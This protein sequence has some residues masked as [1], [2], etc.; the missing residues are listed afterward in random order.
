M[1]GIRPVVRPL[2]PRPS[3][4]FER[5]EAKALLR[6][7]RAGDA[8]ALARARA[9]HDALRSAA[10]AALKLADAQLVIAREYGFASWPRLVRYFEQA[11]RL[12]KRTPS[13]VNPGLWGLEALQAAVPQFIAQHERRST[14][15]ARNL[16]AY[17]PR[18][19]GMP[20]EQ[21]FDTP[22]TEDDARLVIARRNGF[23]TWDALVARVTAEANDPMRRSGLDIPPLRRAL[24]AISAANLPGLQAVTHAHP[25][26]LAPGEYEVATTMQLMA[27]ALRQ[28]RLNVQ[29]DA[30]PERLQ[31]IIDWLVT[32][33]FDLQRELDIQLCGDMRM[34]PDDVQYWIDRGANPNW[35]AP[36]GYSV[37]EHAIVRYRNPAAIDRLAQYA[38]VREPAFWMCAGLG[39]IAGAARYFDGDGRLSAAARAHRPQFDAIAPRAIPPA[40]GDEDDDI[41]HEAAFVAFLCDRTGMMELLISRGL[42]VD[43]LRWETPLVVMAVGNGTVEMTETLIRC[44]ADL[45]LQGAGNGSAREMAREMLESQPPVDVRRRRAARFG[46]RPEPFDTHRRIAELCGLDPD[47]IL[48]ARDARPVPPPSIHPQLTSV[49]R[50]ASDDARRAGALAV[51][52]EHLMYG[53]LRAGYPATGAF[54]Q[55]S[56]MDTDRFRADVGHRVL[57]TDDLLDGETLPLD[58][59][60][61]AVMQAA[62]RIAT[63]AKREAVQSHHLLFALLNDGN[64]VAVSTMAR[65]GGSVDKVNE[66]LAD[67]V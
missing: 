29:R 36:N 32:Q 13:A 34:T 61:H 54:T 5:K 49:L 40:H 16:I 65:Y 55:W 63:A 26:L 25:E 1:S 4:E 14:T 18:F 8:D 44:G 52:A 9:Q 2:P 43:T 45:D 17:V 42:P 21:V 62:T 6:R 15:A 64:G 38:T 66:Y 20:P 24:H 50:I 19:D 67:M 46:R 48:A 11:E 35:V 51:G 3:L 59:D 56:G 30:A 22:I 23:A 27:G 58:A 60:A 39:D 10:P 57:P 31:P 12:A 41:L 7:L 28:Q 47:A 33:G 53:L 37:L